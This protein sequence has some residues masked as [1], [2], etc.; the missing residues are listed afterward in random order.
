MPFGLTNAL[1]VCQ[2]LIDKLLGPEFEPHV[3]AD[4]DD[5]II[6]TKTLLKQEILLSLCFMNS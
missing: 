3:F 1:G 6:V 2:A 5:I 4:L